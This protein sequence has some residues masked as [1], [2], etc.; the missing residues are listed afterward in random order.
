MFVLLWENDR[1]AEVLAQGFA[2]L[3]YEVDLVPGIGDIA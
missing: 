1:D 3:V 2:Q